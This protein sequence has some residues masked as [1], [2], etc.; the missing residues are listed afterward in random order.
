MSSK[1]VGVLS[2]RLTMS[3]TSIAAA[4]EAARLATGKV[5]SRSSRTRGPAVRGRRGRAQIEDT[6]AA[7]EAKLHDRLSRSLKGEKVCKL[8]HRQMRAA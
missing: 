5:R 4:K 7:M 2:G 3:R 6:V 1:M 8:N